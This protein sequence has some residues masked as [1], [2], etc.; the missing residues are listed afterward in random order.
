MNGLS[1]AISG[2]GSAIGR[3]FSIVSFIP[4]LFL[5]SF[6]FALIESNSWNGSQN[7]DWARAGSSL[8]HIGNLGLLVLISAAAGLI[9]HPLQ[10]SLVQLFEGY[11]GTSKL[12]QR[13][14]LTRILHHYNRCKSLRFGPGLD[15][16]SILQ[17]ADEPAEAAKRAMS[18]DGDEDE[19]DSAA[20]K[21]KRLE[22]ASRLDPETRF[23]NRSLADE[24]SRLAK[25]YPDEIT[26]GNH[27]EYDDIMPTRLGNVLRRYERQAGSQ[28]GLDAVSVIQ[29]IAFIAPPDR[30]EYVNDQRQ[31][32]DFSV[33]MSMTSVIA[34]FVAVAFLWRHGLWLLISLATYGIAYLSYRGAIVVAHEYGAAVSAMIDL[35]RFALYDYLRIPRPRDTTA[36]RKMNAQ[37]MSL[38]TYDPTAIVRYSYSNAPGSEDKKSSSS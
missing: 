37:L 20:D 14:R 9:L 3:Y 24:S 12:A 22:E 17:C 4:S 18:E 38:L 23:R 15:A 36:E 6:T 16:A 30:L 8:T 27:V 26:V 21:A 5:V 1:A 32:L 34:T 2:I 11:W 13:I 7:P 19:D 31:L 28:Y 33:R 10:F 35:D 25:G 29:Q